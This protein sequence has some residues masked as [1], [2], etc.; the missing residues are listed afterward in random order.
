MQPTPINPGEVSVET[1]ILMYPRELAAL[2]QQMLDD[3]E[4]NRRTPEPH[5][6]TGPLPN[7]PVHGDWGAAGMIIQR[8]MHHLEESL[9]N[10]QAARTQ[11]A[12]GAL[13]IGVEML[14]QDLA[15]RGVQPARMYI[16]PARLDEHGA[17]VEAAGA[18]AANES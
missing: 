10:G 16:G 5:F 14:K 12:L 3:A 17:P 4:R 8:A 15:R 6:A 13:L 18:P 7:T 2:A 11:P 9:P 1:R